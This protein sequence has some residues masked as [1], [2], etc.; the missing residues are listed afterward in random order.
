[1]TAAAVGAALD[2]RAFAGNVVSEVLGALAGV[3]VALTLVERLVDRA[4]RRRWAIVSRQTYKTMQWVLV[5]A[6]LTFY[7]LLPAPRPTSADPF[8][9]DAGGYLPEALHELARAFANFAET[10]ED[11][12]DARAI[13]SAVDRDFQTVRQT[14]MPRLLALSDEPA[15]LERLVVLEERF[16]TLHYDAW[17]DERF[18]LPGH[19]FAQDL[20]LCIAAMHDVAVALAPLVEPAHSAT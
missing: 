2:P 6:S 17:L 1:M 16:E 18:G 19:F 5:K 20:G 12:L 3:V 11:E 14:L 13:V 9:G 10:T 4:R 7:M 15:L 8:T